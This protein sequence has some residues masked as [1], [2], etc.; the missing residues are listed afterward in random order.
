MMPDTPEKRQADEIIPDDLAPSPNPLPH[1][2][3]RDMITTGNSNHEN[4]CGGEGYGSARDV[5][6]M[7]VDA[8][9]KPSGTY[10]AEKTTRSPK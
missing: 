3:F 7:S 9:F 8:C 10:P 2:D 5:N 6:K 1:K 4:P